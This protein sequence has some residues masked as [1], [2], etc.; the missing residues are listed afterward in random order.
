VGGVAGGGDLR[1]GE[2]NLGAD[3]GAHGGR[4]V[5][6]GRGGRRWR[7]SGRRR[8]R[9]GGVVV[10]AAAAG[11]QQEERGQGGRGYGFELVHGSLR[12]RG[13]LG[14]KRTHP[15]LRGAGANGFK[16]ILHPVELA[17]RIERGQTFLTSSMP[18]C[19]PV[20]AGQ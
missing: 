7:G 17:S 3:A 16:K 19:G 9:G 5:G 6:A 1:L 8:R 11:G 4:Q 13:W 14:E 18:M 12:V 2:G 15:A 20:R 10:I